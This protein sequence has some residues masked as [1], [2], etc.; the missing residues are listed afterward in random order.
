MNRCPELKVLKPR[1][2]EIARAKCGTIENVGTNSV[3]SGNI[4]DESSFDKYF[5]E[6]FKVPTI[7]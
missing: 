3:S 4:V 5:A 2:L 6:K 1:N 7:I